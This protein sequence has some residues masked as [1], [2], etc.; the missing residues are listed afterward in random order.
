MFDIEVRGC[1]VYLGKI[2]IVGEYCVCN[3]VGIVCYGSMRI[4]YE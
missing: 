2:V 1:D 3:Y 4:K